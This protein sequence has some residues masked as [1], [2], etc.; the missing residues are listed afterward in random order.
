[1]G[2]LAGPVA[3]HPQHTEADSVEGAAMAAIVID[4]HSRIADGD[5]TALR[6][7][8]PTYMQAEMWGDPDPATW[9]PG[10][11]TPDGMRRLLRDENVEWM[12]KERAGEDVYQN[13]VEVLHVRVDGTGGLVL[14]RERGSYLGDTWD[15]RNAWLMVRIDGSWK[16]GASLHELAELTGCTQPT[17]VP[18]RRRARR[19][20]VGRWL[21][22]PR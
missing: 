16:I 6:H 5:T 22:H 18:A 9:K 2:T 15:A 7:L 14:T 13:D 17:R 21:H 10:G 20:A 1:M 3:A 19:A 11:T 8:A 12:R 4:Y